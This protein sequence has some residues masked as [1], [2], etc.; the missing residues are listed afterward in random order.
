[1]ILGQEEAVNLAL[2]VI[3]TR[4]HALLEGVPLVMVQCGVVAAWAGFLHGT[5]PLATTLLVANA[6]SGF[7]WFGRV[8]GSVVTEAPGVRAWMSATR[9]LPG[10][11]DLLDLPPGRARLP[12][13]AHPPH[14][15][16]R[17]RASRS[18][19]TIA[20]SSPTCWPELPRWI[21]CPVPPVAIPGGLGMLEIR[22]RTF[23]SSSWHGPPA[24]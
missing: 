2:I 14:A 15:G 22:S 12:R 3:L 18:P 19:P 4:Q 9:P 10:G 11:G 13:S 5:W 1:M 7:D 24:T 16:R 8:A 17:T 23:P 21:A 6:V 20:S